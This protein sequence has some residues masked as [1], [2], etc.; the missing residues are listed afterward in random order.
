MEHLPGPKHITSFYFY[1]KTKWL[2]FWR[3]LTFSQRLYLTAIV[4]FIYQINGETTPPPGVSENAQ[5]MED[6]FSPSSFLL[7]IIIISAL[8]NEL[9]PKL[10]KFWDSLPGKAV[11]LIFYAF[12]ANYALAYAAGAINDITGVS[13]DHFPYTH[14]LSLMLSLPSWFF[15]STLSILLLVPLLQPFYVLLLLLM[16]PFG[17]HTMW[18]P[19][20]YRFP[21]ITSFIRMTL[22]VM[23]FVF[24]LM[25]T[26]SS[27]M[28][29]GMSTMFTNVIESFSN[30]TVSSNITKEIDKELSDNSKADA[31][32]A[33]QVEQA[34]AEV[35][36]EQSSIMS[37]NIGE[38]EAESISLSER[39]EA[40]DNRIKSILAYFIY[41]LEADSYSRCQ[42]TEGSRMVELN[43]YEILEITQLSEQE[44]TYKYEVKPCIS[45]AIGHQFK[46]SISV[47][48]EEKL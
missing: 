39:A 15:I 32:N 7:V 38:S 31:E 22:C 44:R 47:P 3:S 17:L 5:M 20:E 6:M 14:N 29:G 27:G 40:Y 9:W 25:F 46:P 41:E 10:M 2:T 37:I 11:V 1:I 35:Q 12:I 23:L 8:L 33:E 26:F 34:I 43:D 4:F 36:K 16:R 28:L 42:V 45:V 30:T 18:H 13:A 21:I 48:T 19:P 24:V